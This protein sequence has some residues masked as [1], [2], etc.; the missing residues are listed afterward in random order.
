VLCASEA[1]PE[2][3]ML[4]AHAHEGIHRAHVGADV[5][6]AHVCTAAAGWQQPHQHVDGCRLA[7]TWC[8]W[9]GTWH[10]NQFMLVDGLS[11]CVCKVVGFGVFR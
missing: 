3:I 4:W 2:Q 11:V 6:P 8:G 9:Q 5:M 1:V 10:R 7:G